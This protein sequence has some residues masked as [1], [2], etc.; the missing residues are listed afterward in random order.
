M[1]RM[2]EEGATVIEISAV[3]GHDIDS[4]QSIIDT[5]VPRQTQMAK[6]AIRHLENWEKK[7]RAK[8]Q[9]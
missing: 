5:Y 9:K 1:T 4:T 3:S 6:N 2:A 7:G 8:G